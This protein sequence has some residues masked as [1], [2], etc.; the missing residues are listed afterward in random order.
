MRLKLTRFDMITASKFASVYEKAREVGVPN[1]TMHS[2]EEGPADWVRQTLALGINRVDHGVHAADDPELLKELAARSTL[3]T[4]CPLSNVRLRVHK[5]V[6]ESPIPLLLEAGVPFSINSDDPSYFGEPSFLRCCSLLFL[7]T[8][9]RFTETG[10]YILDNY[11]AVQKA[12]NFPKETWRKIA[13]NSVNGSW[14]DEGRKK[15]I[16]SL[17]DAHFQEWAEKE[18]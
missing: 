8:D 12:F 16:V 9:H 7:V 4:V 14:C 18:I 5:D 1:L 13:M 6:K 17:I 2:G 15:E 11:L 3:L 10:G